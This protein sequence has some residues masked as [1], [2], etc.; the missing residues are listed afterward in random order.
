M[1]PLFGNATATALVVLSATAAAQSPL[2]DRALEL[3]SQRLGVSPTEAMIVN[4]G[5]AADLV[6]TNGVVWS[7]KVARIDGEGAAASIALEENG[8]ELEEFEEREM[9]LR[10]QAWGARTARLQELVREFP[11]SSFKVR[12]SVKL[13]T[14]PVAR[15]DVDADYATVADQMDRERERVFKEVREETALAAVKLAELLPQATLRVNEQTGDIESELNL[16]DMRV[17]EDHLPSLREIDLLETTSPIHPLIADGIP[18]AGVPQFGAATWSSLVPWLHT[19]GLG[20]E[21]AFW[22]DGLPGGHTNPLIPGFTREW[23][24]RSSLHAFQTFGVMTYQDLAIPGSSPNAEVHAFE[25]KH[26]VDFQQNREWVAGQLANGLRYGVLQCSVAP[27]RTSAS[28]AGMGPSD[29]E[30]LAF[31]FG[32]LSVVANGNRSESYYNPDQSAFGA[33]GYNVLGVGGTEPAGIPGKASDDH[34]WSGSAFLNPPT[35]W[36][37]HHKPDVVAMAMLGVPRLGGGGFDSEQGTSLAAPIV[38]GLVARLIEAKPVV[39]FRPELIKAMIGASAIQVDSPSGV[40]PTERGGWGNVVGTNLAAIVNRI[41]AGYGARSFGCSTM[42]QTQVLVTGVPQ[43]AGRLRA[44]ISWANDTEVVPV[45][46]S[47]PRADLDLRLVK[48]AFGSAPV[49]VATSATHDSVMEALDSPVD[50]FTSYDLV[51]VRQ[52]CSSGFSVPLAYAWRAE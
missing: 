39:Q 37:D 46:N 14:S 12:I 26:A 18:A 3:G 38:S 36:G 9:E 16:D 15:P 24:S 28:G 34:V 17:V 6:S 25:L 22:D 40:L 8:T 41:G 50:A 31:R 27:H 7:F 20:V 43:R 4:A 1:S 45:A 44:A 30:L 35:L 13:T 29:L 11:T 51:M 10:V 19:T 47:R 23:G 33:N 42:P 5:S 2:E 32:L 21:V 52:R 48:R 49:V